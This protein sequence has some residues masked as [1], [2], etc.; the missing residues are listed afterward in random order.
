MPR[1]GRV[2]PMP[3]EKDGAVAVIG[4]QGSRCTPVLLSQAVKPAVSQEA[5]TARPLGCKGGGPGSDTAS[6]KA[7][8][9]GG[10]L[11]IKEASS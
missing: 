4:E 9:D 1:C 11:D 5:A 8:R 10:C 6:G 3:D 2:Q 7:A